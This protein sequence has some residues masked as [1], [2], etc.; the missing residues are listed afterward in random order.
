MGMNEAPPSALADEDVRMPRIFPLMSNRA[1]PMAVLPVGIDV[2]IGE[3]VPFVS[4]ISPWP[5]IIV[6]V[7]AME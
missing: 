6:E 2:A 5:N 7:P 4:I 1:L 3:D